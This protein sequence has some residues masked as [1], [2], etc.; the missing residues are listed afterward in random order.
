MD[1]LIKK[2][3]V[4]NIDEVL[5]EGNISN[6]GEVVLDMNST[7]SFLFSKKEDKNISYLDV[8]SNIDDL[9]QNP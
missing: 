9:W 3:S 6:T 8:L 4:N 2:N 1:K 5:R 7:N